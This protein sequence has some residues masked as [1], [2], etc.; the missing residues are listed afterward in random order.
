MRHP[1]LLVGS[2]GVLV[3]AAAAAGVLLTPAGEALRDFRV[4]WQETEV[5]SQRGAPYALSFSTA[6]ENA[7]VVDVSNLTAV[8]VGLEIRSGGSRVH[9]ALFTVMVRA[10]SG[11]EST[12]QV[13][14]TAGTQGAVQSREFP[15][16]LA[17]VPA[18]DVVTASS[19]AE[20]W[21]R[22][23]ERASDAG[24]GTWVVRIVGQA[25]GPVGAVGGGLDAY[26]ASTGVRAMAYRAVLDPPVAG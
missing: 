10:P 15:F 1:D 7:F 21:E 8:N 9:N 24:R 17:Q 2:V 25:E 11:Q 16:V 26:T 14:F 23:S 6:S 20:A 4:Q 18:M 13:R 12:G 5:L 19:T 22:L 3:V